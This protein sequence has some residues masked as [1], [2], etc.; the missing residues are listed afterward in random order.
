MAESVL[1]PGTSAFT[2]Q[3]WA[4]SFYPAG[5]KPR[6]YLN[7]QATKFGA[8]ELGRAFYA[9]LTDRSLSEFETQPSRYVVHVAGR[10]RLAQE[11]AG[12]EVRVDQDDREVT[13]QAPANDQ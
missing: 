10:T 7:F 6:D 11:W 5:R 13:I 8:V 9:R 1:R 4:G 2:A 3:G 12:E